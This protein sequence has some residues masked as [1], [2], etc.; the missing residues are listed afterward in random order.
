MAGVFNL[1]HTQ[2][3]ISTDT[4]SVTHNSGYE[5]VKIKVIVNGESREDLISDIVTD[6]SDPTNKLI[7]YLMSA[8]TGVV[9][10]LKTDFVT[11]GELS[12]TGVHGV[13][14]TISDQIISGNKAFTDT[15]SG[16]GPTQDHHLT[17]KSYVD[18]I[19]GSLQTNIG[20]KPDTLLEL[21]DTPSSYDDDKYLRS[22]TSGAEWADVTCATNDIFDVY[23]NT[24]GQTF[25]TSTITLNLDVVRKDTGNSVFTLS[26]DEVTINK[27]DTFI[28]IYRTSTDIST[29]T[30]RSC[31]RAIL[32][33]DTGGGFAEVDGFRGY[34]Y[35]HTLDE[36]DNT[37]M[38]HGVL[39]VTTGDKFR[40]RL[41]REVGGSTI[42]TIVDAS[43][44]TIFS[45]KGVRGE[46]G[47]AGQD[48][49]PGT[50][51]TINILEDGLIEA[52]SVS[53]LNFEGNVEGNV[54]VTSGVSYTTVN[55]SAI[56]T[57]QC[58]STNTTNVNTSTPVAVGWNQEDLKDDD[59]FTHSNSTNNSRV[60]VD[61]NGWYEVS[62]NLYYDGASSRSNVR[63]RIRKN[64]SDYL[65]RGASVN[66]TRNSTNES[67]SIGSGPFL[68]Q[69]NDDDYIEL[70]TDQQ[71]TSTTC[72]MVADD[73][74]IR[75]TYFRSS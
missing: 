50:G 11:V 73:N 53:S 24:G 29:G 65:G 14:Y 10:V 30:S 60:Y 3:F 41:N 47:S 68:V 35:N 25:T 2:A 28:F 26:A 64:G 63:G 45:L 40:I 59:Y 67:G 62:Y 71:G 36:A 12:A 74:Y 57:I 22:T 21:V 32:E 4:I 15:I 1:I 61:Q 42:R 13:V 72:S 49:Q 20:A 5:Y 38:V 39:D 18:T 66:Y 19:S 23:D 16:V 69:L 37:C 55:V 48:G 52:S 7:V 51:S 44:L 75:L 46:Q 58:Y 31:S 34:M 33:R 8:Q 70:M 6:V 54:T 9:Q 27:T 43:G 17:T 56:K